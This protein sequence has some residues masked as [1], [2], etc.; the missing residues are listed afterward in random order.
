MWCIR[1][2]LI[3]SM[4]AAYF[5]FFFKRKKKGAQKRCSLFSRNPGSCVCSFVFGNVHY[6]LS[7]DIAGGLILFLS[8]IWFVRFSGRRRGRLETNCTASPE[9]HSVVSNPWLTT[10]L[11]SIS[12][13]PT[14]LLT[15]A[16]HFI[17]PLPPWSWSIGWTGGFS[18]LMV[19]RKLFTRVAFQCQTF[20]N[21]MLALSSKVP[22]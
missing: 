10:L 17:W 12:L 15:F 6:R 16:Q 2:A 19:L 14:C 22:L 20:L 5:I 13:T 3:L 21:R 9:G 11:H 8:V 7:G 4:N 18:R 1:C